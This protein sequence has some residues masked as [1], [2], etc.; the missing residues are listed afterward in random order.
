[1]TL[2]QPLHV[3]IAAL[4]HVGLRRQRNEDCISIGQ[5]SINEPIADPWL[6]SQCL[7]TACVC[8]VADGMGGHPAGD[9]ASRFV[10]E[11]LMSRLTEGAVDAPRI[12][13]AV[14]DANRSLFAEMTRVPALY[15][16][17]T[18][19]AGLVAHQ[20]GVFAFN[21]GDSRVYRIR[22][23]RIE[24]LGQDDTVQV[25]TPPFAGRKASRVLSQCLGGFSGG[26]QIDPHITR[27]PLEAGAE[28][29]IC[30]DG[31]HDMLDDPDIEG[32]LQPDLAT[33]VTTLFES[34]M[35]AG[36]I[37]N[38]SIIHARIEPRNQVA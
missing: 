24:R 30:S 10:I 33:T 18:T 7:D 20:A 28:F 36:G 15:G 31:L 2:S 6:V 4:T 37:D 21:V 26:D 14:R 23:G 12:A 35:A 5:Q 9:V 3:R 32:C 27:L 34:A 29:L 22:N 25:G 38:I 1:M 16:M 11:Q 8:L 19:I 17:G 13:D